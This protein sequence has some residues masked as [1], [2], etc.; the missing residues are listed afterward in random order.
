L[1]SNFSHLRQ[2]FTQW[3]VVFSLPANAL[4]ARQLAIRLIRLHSEWWLPMPLAPH[5][6]D[7]Q[8]WLNRAEESRVLAEQMID[9]TA[10]EMM[11]R[12]VD[13][14]RKLAER[15]SVRLIGTGAC[16]RCGK[17]SAFVTSMLDPKTG[18]TAH[19]VRCECG[20]ISWME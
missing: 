6:N 9:E 8:H 5:F 17:R 20:D 14:Y 16:P 7:P 13:D 10:K 2:L 12:I 1:P 11:L 19:V 4:L 15:A 3:F 18:R